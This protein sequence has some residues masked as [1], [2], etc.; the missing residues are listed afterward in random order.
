EVYRVADYF[1]MDKLASLA[2][3]TLGAELDTKLS[4]AQ[5]QADEPVDWLPEISEVLRLVY[6]NTPYGDESVPPMRKA[7]LTFVRTARF[8]LSN[9]AKFETYLGQINASEV[10]VFRAIRKT[11][12]LHTR[13]PEHYKFYKSRPSN[14]TDKRYFTHV[15]AETL[16]VEAAYSTCAVK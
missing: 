9:N 6:Q 13:E 4:L 1:M 5:L 15:V 11:G 3:T 2:L 7:F 14:R 16:S 8:S 10:D 12:D